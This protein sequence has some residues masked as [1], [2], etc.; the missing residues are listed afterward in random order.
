MLET[1]TFAAK[2]SPSLCVE[3]YWWFKKILINQT[4][5]KLPLKFYCMILVKNLLIFCNILAVFTTQETFRL[6]NDN[7][8]ENIMNLIFFFYFGGVMCEIL[9]YVTVFIF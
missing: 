6:N 3:T 8:T 7:G 9:R 2:R 4:L 1:R 5:S